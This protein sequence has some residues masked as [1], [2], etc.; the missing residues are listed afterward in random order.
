[1][2]KLVV[3]PVDPQIAYLKKGEIKDRYYNP[4]NYFDEVHVIDLSTEQLTPEQQQSIS[5]LAGKAKFIVHYF[6]CPSKLHIFKLKKQILEKVKEIKPDCIRAF[7]V[8]HEGYL[9]SYCSKKLNI[10]FVLSIH[11]NYAHHKY[12]VMWSESFKTGLLHVGF[13]SLFLK[14][15]VK[16]ANEIIYVY[17]QAFGT[18]QKYNLPAEHQHLIYNKVY[19]KPAKKEKHKKFTLIYVGNFFRVKNQKFLLDVIEPLDVNLIL[20]GKGHTREELVQYCQNKPSLK[21]KVIFIEAVPNKELPKYYA[22]ADAFISA[23]LIQEIAIPAIEAMALG[24]PIIHRKPYSDEP[25]DPLHDAMYTVDFN[26]Q[27]F[28]DAIEKLKTNQQLIKEYSQKSKKAFE[29]VKGEKMEQK[30]KQVYQDLLGE[31]K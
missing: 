26:I 23:T 9:A 18:T 24:L 25:K 1:M 11:G 19:F 10:P 6:Y 31:N 3:F 21:D 22:K 16:Q 7:G 30:E 27:S 29:N 4:G 13:L 5:Q 8:Y 12:L 28:R 14:Q 2:K 17:T 15:I 20:I